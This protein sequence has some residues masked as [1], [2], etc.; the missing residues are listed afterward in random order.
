MGYNYNNYFPATYGNSMGANQYQNGYSNGFNGMQPNYIPQQNN[1]QP[2]TNMQWVQG[3]EGAKA[4][5]QP[6][7]TITPLWDSD[8]QTI[9]LKST[10][11]SGRPSI[12][13]LDYSYR[14]Q[15]NQQSNKSEVV[16]VQA[17][18]MSNYAT[19][20]DMTSIKDQLSALRNELANMNKGNKKGGNGNDAK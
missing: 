3:I 1:Q 15:S 8:A 18:D 10:D 6:P 2:N 13:P 11:A 20:E 5:Q 19:K 7:N 9:Y 17:H 16:D 4:F 12:E 14:N